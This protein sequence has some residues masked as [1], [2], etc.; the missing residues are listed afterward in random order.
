MIRLHINI[1][2]VATIRNARGTV[3]PDPVAAAAICELA[4]ADG[5]TAHLREDRRHIKDDDI[6]R[7]RSALSTMLNLE[8]A[9]T[10]EMCGIAERV[11]PNVI[12]L[13][14]ERRAELTTE[15]GLDV[16]AAR[17]AIEKVSAMAARRSIKLSLFIAPDEAHVRLSHELGAAQVEFHTGEYCHKQGEARVAELS[18][19]QRASTLA[20]GLGLEVAAG[21]G[22][23]RFNV[24]DVAA[25]PE[26]VE[27]NIGHSVIADAVLIGMDRAVRD[28]RS[29]IERGLA[30]R[31]AR[32]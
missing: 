14:P 29:A 11:V 6:A 3:Y 2:H 5:I 26:V 24:I 31:R 15:G 21:H 25:I 32:G 8:M 27:L 1:D 17:A 18:R 16:V 4:G 7:L 13:V 30:L 22:L 12:T 20:H 19:L 23:T 9:A 10:D 28:L